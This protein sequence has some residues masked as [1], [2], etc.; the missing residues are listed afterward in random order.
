VFSAEIRNNG[1]AGS[2]PVSQIP[3]FLTFSLALKYAEYPC[4]AAIF[5]VN[6]EPHTGTRPSARLCGANKTLA[7]NFSILTS[8]N[9]L[10]AAPSLNYDPP[11]LAPV[12][13]GFDKT[14]FKD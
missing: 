12:R 13:R 7:V 8:K 2:Q 9:H 5:L 3:E 14:L 10:A 1:E 4:S 11:V 6:S